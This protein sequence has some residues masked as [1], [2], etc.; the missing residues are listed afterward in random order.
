MDVLLGVLRMEALKVKSKNIGEIIQNLRKERGLTQAQLAEKLGIS[1][2]AVIHYENNNRK[3]NFEALAKLAHF[4]QVSPTYLAGQSDEK[5]LNTESEKVMH[6]NTLPRSIT[7][8]QTVKIINKCIE[9]NIKVELE[10]SNQSHDFSFFMLA[11]VFEARLVGTELKLSIVM[12]DDNEPSLN[13]Y[14][15][16]RLM[17]NGDFELAVR[18]SSDGKYILLDTQN[19]REA[20]QGEML[21]A[22]SY[23]FVLHC[24]YEWFQQNFEY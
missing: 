22:R 24:D 12:D 3:P 9:N 4:F 15:Q 6:I 20:P 8:L 16:I 18:Q 19:M 2:S 10:L 17:N 11:R 1:K 21:K 13:L 5:G 14:H 7:F 23:L